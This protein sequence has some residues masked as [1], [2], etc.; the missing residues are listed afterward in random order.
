MEA[1]SRVRSIEPLGDG[2]YRITRSDGAVLETFIC[3]CYSFGIAEYI[4]T[5]ENLGRLDA[6]IINSNWC[7]YTDQLK[8]QCRDERVGLFRIGD[9]MAALNRQDFWAY[10]DQWEESRLKKRGLL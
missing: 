6:I 10:L 3:E 1:H 7:G 9:F 2:R 8:V 4:E 5:T